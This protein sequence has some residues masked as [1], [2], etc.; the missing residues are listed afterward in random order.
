[1]TSALQWT[2]IVVG[3]I[4]AAAALVGVLLTQ[5][6]QRRLSQE[7]KVWQEQ[8]HLYVD[9]IAWGRNVEYIVQPWNDKGPMPV[10][11]V[12]PRLKDETWDRAWAYG[13]GEVL[14]LVIDLRKMITDFDQ[15]STED[16]KHDEKRARSVEQAAKALRTQARTELQEGRPRRESLW[17]FRRRRN[18]RVRG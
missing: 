17:P 18:S 6:S 9:L 12:V 14:R 5:S 8:A 1:M 10:W 11:S 4:T 13:S 2:P 15:N 16:R 7:S 3:V